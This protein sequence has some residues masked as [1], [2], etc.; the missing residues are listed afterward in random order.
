MFDL[1]LFDT[2]EFEKKEF[3]KKE[4]NLKTYFDQNNDLKLLTYSKKTISINLDM[5]INTIKIIFNCYLIEKEQ[6]SYNEIIQ[7]IELINKFYG[8]KKNLLN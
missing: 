8:L 2:E 4:F 6:M 1:K 7:V 5:L 3:E